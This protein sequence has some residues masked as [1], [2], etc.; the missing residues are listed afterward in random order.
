MHRAAPRACHVK[1]RQDICH[2]D[3]GGVSAFTTRQVWFFVDG[4][5]TLREETRVREIIA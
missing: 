5:E 2:K 3:L 4:V 1:I